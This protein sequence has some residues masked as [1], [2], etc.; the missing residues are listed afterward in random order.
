MLNLGDFVKGDT[1]YVPWNSAGADG[2]SITRATNGTISVYSADGTTQFTTGVTDTE[3]FDALTGVHLAKIVTT[4]SDYVPNGTYTVVLSAATIDSKTVN[5]AIAQ[6]TIMRKH[7][8]QSLAGTL[9]A[10]PSSTTVTLPSP[11]IATDDVY[12]GQTLTAVYGTGLN[13]SVVIDD[14]VGSTKVATVSPA[15]VVGFDTTTVFEIIKTPRASTGAPPAVDMVQ[16]LGTA[17]ATPATAGLLDVNVKQ[18]STDATAADNLEAMFDGTGYA[19]GTI[20]LNVDVNKIN[21]VVITGD[22]SGT[23]FNV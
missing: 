10:V 13:Q 7:S 15:P 2:A 9:A 4:G 19:G 23:P 6:F 8:M 22:G 11:A 3:D 1:V 18:V 21:G 16:I 12:N 17:V 5:S 14:Y 20:N